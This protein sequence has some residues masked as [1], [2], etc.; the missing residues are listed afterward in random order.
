VKYEKAINNELNQRLQGNAREI[1]T[2]LNDFKSGLIERRNRYLKD[3]EF[4]YNLSTSEIQ[5]LRNISAN[6]LRTDLAS[7]MTFFARNGKLLVSL[8]KDNQD[9]IRISPGTTSGNLYLSEEN[10]DKIRTSADY[11]FVEYPED[12]GISLI[13]LSKVR[14]NG[15]RLVGYLEQLIN[16]NDSFMTK[17]KER[18]K[19]EMLIV[20]PNGQVVAATHPDFEIYKK[21][22]F[23]NYIQPGEKSFFELSVRGDPY[24]FILYPIKWGQ[25]E[26]FLGLG[27]SKS[28]ALAVL[29]NVNY[30]FMTVVGA[31][32][33][34]LLIFIF[35]A[36]TTLIK[37]VIDLVEAI[38]QVESSEK[39]VEIPV[40][41][42]TEIGLLT[43][44]FNSMS[45]NVIRARAD[46]K[47]KVQELEKAN[48]ELIDTQA[49]LVH[50][51]K[52]I[53]LG[54]LVAGVAHELN[55]PIGFIYSNMT[56]L[57]D[58]SEK[59]IRF[60]ETAEK[61]PEKIKSLKKELEVDY[62]KQDLPKLIF[63]CEDGARRTRDIVIGLRNFSRL[64]EAKLKEIDIHQAVDDTLNLLTGE[65]KNRIQIIKKY[66][67]L[68][69]VTCYASHINQVFMNL[70]SNAA[71]AIEGNGNI[72]I[73]TNTSTKNGE[74]FVEI[75]FQDSGKGMSS[76]VMDKIFDPFFSTKGVGQ[77]T[78]LGL[79]I[80]YGI[81]Q[82]HG[83]EIQVKSQPGIGTEFIV[84]MPV[85]AKPINTEDAAV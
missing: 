35:V 78:G 83:G 37:P 73:S 81:V 41:S 74:D 59:L 63:S 5:T 17:L 19:L 18:M 75:S 77:G 2:I 58:Y 24:G 27:A 71:Q 66:K 76:E 39:I 49:R 42:D 32:I 44:S 31:V 55:N 30:A 25:T 72:W 16:L 28:E 53:S 4:I 23:Q 10:L 7:S 34:L 15:N 65:I 60:A 45:S 62:I 12:G 52:M 69:L 26:I 80:S 1:N 48:Q 54:Q 85:K 43:E 82:K 70:L 64:E 22:F 3:T 20:R 36:S 79:S 51:A 33:V 50:S 8:E 29:E 57:R 11:T 56:H 21:D 46:L 13:L 14:G 68:P 40:R 6:W 61:E 67:K 47:R 38:D 84:H 9:E